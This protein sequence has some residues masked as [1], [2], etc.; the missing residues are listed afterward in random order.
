MPH[1]P[2]ITVHTEVAQDGDDVSVK[3]TVNLP[4]GV[5]IE[6]HVPVEPFLIPTVVD[7]DDLADLSVSYPDPVT[8]LLGWADASV[9]VLEG[10]LEF[11]VTGKR[12]T[13][14]DPIVGGLSFQPCVG[15]ACLPPRRVMWTAPASG[16]ASY[17]VIEALAA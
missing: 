2:A 7:A 1:D 12:L 17:S 15:G 11:V 16:V 3:L 5:H 10:T 9:T 13:T 6:P 14:G 4:E 8:K